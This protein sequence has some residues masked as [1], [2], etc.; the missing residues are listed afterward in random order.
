MLCPRCGEPCEQDTVDI[1]VGEQPV[2]PWGCPNCHWVERVD[3][4]SPF[5]D[6]P[7]ENPALYDLAKEICHAMGATWTDPR[8]GEKHPPPEKP[9]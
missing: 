3:T 8:T 1:G 2:G 5:T 4:L 7:M 6:D 9:K